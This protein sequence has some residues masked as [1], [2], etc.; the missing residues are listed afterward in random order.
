[1]ERKTIV[2][3]M[4]LAIALL[5]SAARAQEKHPLPVVWS[6]CDVADW[7][8]AQIGRDKLPKTFGANVDAL[9][10]VSGGAFVNADLEAKEIVAFAGAAGIDVVNLAQ[11][12]LGSDPGVLAGAIGSGKTKFVSASFSLA[13]A[14]WPSHA[15]VERGGRRFGV[16]GIAMKLAGELPAGVQYVEPRAALQRAIA[17]VGSV[18][19]VIV[20]ADAPVSECATLIKEFPQIDAMVVSARGGGSVSV[21]AQA[22]IVRAPAGDQALAILPSDPKGEPFGLMIPRPHEASE[23]YRELAQTRVAHLPKAPAITAAVK[24]PQR[25]APTALE[26]NVMMP[27]GLTASNRAAVVTVRSAGLLDAFAGKPA[28]PGKKYLVL[29]LD[30]R[31]ILTPQI[32]RD[33]Q[34]PVAYLIQKL[35]D[36][37]YLVADEKRVLQ[38]MA[39]DAAGMLSTGQM[40]LPRA[41]STASGKLVYQVDAAGAPKE[42]ALRM[43]DYAHG[44]FVLPVLARASTDAKPVENPVSPAMKNE[45]VEIAAY[46][47]MKSDEVDGKRAPA[48]FAFVSIDLRAK[49]QFKY[50]ADATAFSSNAKPGTKTQVGTVADWTDS[51]KYLQLVADGEF[52]YA[53]EEQT[54]LAAAPRFLPD[55]MTGG[56]VVFI[57][58]RDSKSLELRCDFPNAKTPE[59]KVIRPRGV[60]LALEG[61]RPTLP[62]PKP[63]AKIEDDIFVVNIT[64]QNAADS[65]AGQDASNGNRFV[66]LDITVNNRGKDGEFFQ[67]V[68]QLKLADASGGKLDPD[69]ATQRGVHRPETLVWIPAGERRSFQVAYQMPTTETRPRLAYTGV[70]KAEVI[71]LAALSPAPANAATAQPKAV[72]PSAQPSSPVAIAPATPAAP[73]PA[74]PSPV[75]ARQ[76]ILDVDGKKFPARVPIRP[77]LQPKGLSGVGLTAEQVN[78]AIDKGAAFLWQ[79]IQSED[80]ARR[81]HPFGSER[82]HVLAALALVHSNA[83][84]RFPDFDGQLRQFLAKFDPVEASDTYEIGLYCMLVE[85]YGDPTF[86]PQLR[87]ASQWLI[88]NQGPDGTWG[89]GVH[90][91]PK[92]FKQ[93]EQK[94]VLQ[95]AGGRPLDGSDTAAPLARSTPWEKGMDGDNS[96]SQYALLGLHAASRSRAKPSAEI[97]TRAL[98]AHQ[99]RQGDDGGWA[100][101]SPSS[102]Y[103]SMT[104]AGICALALARH[105]LNLTDSAI[106]Q[107]IERGLGWLNANFSVTAHPKSS[108]GWL[109]YYLYSVERAGRILDT[110]FIGEHE[111]YPQG[112]AFLVKEQDAAGGW[113]GV[114]EE[115]DTRLASSFAMLFLTRATASLA[116]APKQGPGTL[117]TTVALPPGKKL[118]IILD[119]SGS[120]L[121][122]MEGRPKFDI[123]RDAVASL[124]K[125]LPANT[126]VALRV[127][128]Y[129]KRAIEEGASEDSKLLVPMAP[130]KKDALLEL[131]QGI[132]ARGKTPLAYSLEQ[133]RG[134]LPAATEEAPLTLLLLTD[135]GEDTQPRRD[136][137][138]AAAALAKVPNLRVRIVGFDINREDWTQQL[139]AMATACGG[140]Y[141]AAAKSDS[142]LRELRTAVFE[143]PETYTVLDANGREIASGPFGK[144]AELAAGKYTLRTTYANQTFEETFWI[145]AGA[146]TAVTFQAALVQP[147]AASPS[148]PAAAPASPASATP[149]QGKFC[150]HCG[151]KLN[152]TAKFCTSCGAAV[153]G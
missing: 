52:G 81:K 119:A 12:D 153:G 60:T 97:W 53:P 56:R 91:D 87:R 93:D 122:E 101:R 90:L 47:L 113:K 127:Y 16:V 126:E 50:S 17:E 30:F 35:S 33:Q 5:V 26:P 134:E 148:A 4:M 39:L 62:N 85:S 109:Y 68:E 6:A 8:L 45:V 71:E 138:A 77:A 128:G 54:A 3:G 108:E 103:G 141:L 48:G 130:L 100:Y 82:E 34:V 110:E 42:L 51:R 80:V 137:V 95:V 104:C 135:G 74:A 63:L 40:M 31:N 112:A 124:V 98:K 64:N 133:A 83:H 152:A 114:R 92:L 65:F 96:V 67:T 121:E 139:Q 143:T 28:A 105:E 14:T 147:A 10:V 106:E 118:Y 27:L 136:P 13:G 125:E 84:K 107:Q 131:L 86:V 149:A 129:R 94:K 46:D 1:M 151:A 140:Q 38:P 146:T 36:H 78:T 49:S 66:V 79:Y 115:S 117:K 2:C 44:H 70:S 32:V 61:K 15:V 58:P 76:E 123:A 29:D 72:A 116:D 69:P 73:S 7:R 55:V 150:T 144:V 75:Q 43:Y 102:S 21:P 132:R 22:R 57:A 41:G 88:E 23:R 20:L 9:V 59:G 24:A 89:Y 145:N 19:G 120:M 37:L 111:W 18:D 142:L 99:S 25:Q 11:R